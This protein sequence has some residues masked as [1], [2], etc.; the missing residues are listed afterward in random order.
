MASTDSP[1]ADPERDKTLPALPPSLTITRASGTME[2]Q[3]VTPRQPSSKLSAENPFADPSSGT[4]SNSASP[5]TPYPPNSHSPVAGSATRGNNSQNGAAPR[6]FT[7]AMA[8]S[9]SLTAD[10]KPSSSKST[11]STAPS[12]SRTGTTTLISSTHGGATFTTADRNPFADPRAPARVQDHG[13]AGNGTGPSTPL[14]IS[15]GT[16]IYNQY[17]TPIVGNHY[18]LPTP[19]VTSSIAPTPPPKSPLRKVKPLGSNRWNFVTAITDRISL[20]LHPQG[21]DSVSSLAARQ[22][23]ALE[24]AQRQ[25]A[26][27]AIE[28]ARASGSQPNLNEPHLRPSPST[29]RLAAELIRSRDEKDTNRAYAAVLT[30]TPFWIGIV[31]FECGLVSTVAAIAV[32]IEESKHGFETKMGKGEVFWLTS[33]IL[34]MVVAVIVAV[35]VWAKKRRVGFSGADRGILRRLGCDEVGLLD[36]SVVRDVEMG[37]MEAAGDG[38]DVQ[39]G[40]APS[41]QE[42]V[43]RRPRGPMPSA[44]SLSSVRTG[45]P[46]WQAMYPHPKQL[47]KM[48]SWET[49]GNTPVRRGAYG[50]HKDSNLA[51]NY[52]EQ[53]SKLPPRKAQPKQKNQQ[54]TSSTRQP[55][56]DNQHFN[57]PTRRYEDQRAPVFRG[58]VAFEN[59]TLT[60]SDISWPLRSSPNAQP[61]VNIHPEYPSYQNPPP[62]SYQGLQQQYPTKPYSSNSVASNPSVSP[63]AGSNAINTEPHNRTRTG[64]ESRVE[65]LSPLSSLTQIIHNA[66]Q[67]SLPPHHHPEYIHGHRVASEERVRSLR[68]SLD[69]SHSRG[70]SA[71]RDLL[72]VQ[73]NSP[74][75][76]TERLREYVAEIEGDSDE[77]ERVDRPRSRSVRAVLESDSD[78]DDAVVEDTVEERVVEAHDQKTREVFTN[79]KGHVQVKEQ[80]RGRSLGEVVREKMAK[81]KEAGVESDPEPALLPTSPLRERE[82]FI[83]G[84]DTPSQ[85]SMKTNRNSPVNSPSQTPNKKSAI[86]SPNK[87]LTSSPL[88]CKG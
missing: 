35:Y 42:S 18:L 48:V 11:A 55:K 14:P 33:S 7:S 56:T 70:H 80:P 88:S 21:K 83:V 68:H 5:A 13:H 44:D 41:P 10:P 1:F 16:P 2:S 29:V 77:E 28:R 63:F 47:K 22:A 38:E 67:S 69:Q 40:S 30:S 75:A 3:P 37:R 17:T 59:Q 27:L 23:V 32:I 81:L 46:E 24:S 25:D 6:D 65:V 4:H 71:S 85:T 73:S 20:K 15:T 79:D 9:N 45:D 84:D 39:R 51:R 58:Q 78:F 87:G 36:R 26:L 86:D 76:A 66:S 52:D 53:R 49:I 43:R 34:V 60:R 8:A 57:N 12:S 50:L 54:F 64:T 31:W 61:F 62:T 82:I 72:R 19:S 74:S